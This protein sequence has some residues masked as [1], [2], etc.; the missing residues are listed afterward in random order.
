MIKVERFNIVQSN[1]VDYDVSVE[2]EL[3]ADQVAT[4]IQ[5]NE[6]L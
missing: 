5:E 3:Y 2:F 4:T 6:S 1:E